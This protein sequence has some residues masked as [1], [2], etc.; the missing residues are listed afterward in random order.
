MTEEREIAGFVV[1]FT[2]GI[3]SATYSLSQFWSSHIVPVA[4][5]VFIAAFPLILLLHPSRRKRDR[6]VIMTL[7]V[8]AA[9]GCGLLTG[10]THRL[11]SIAINTDFTLVPDWLAGLGVRMKQRIDSL[12]FSHNSTNAVI[13]ALITGDRS[14]L[15]K[16]LSSI[17]RES[18][19]S[20]ILAL[21]GLHLG[22]I[23]GIIPRILSVAGK[24]LNARRL[25]YILTVSACAIYTA[26]TGAGASITRAFLFIFIG[27]T[28]ALSGR[29]RN[30]V[31]TL[32]ASLFIQLLF[33][34]GSAKDIGFQLSYAAMAGI[35]F[36]YPRLK[37]LWPEG[38]GGIMKR[39]WESAA[40]SISCQLT[41]GPLAYMYFGTFARHFLLTN[42]LAMPLT[43]IIIPISMLTAGLDAAGI[44]PD[45][46]LKATEILVCTMIDC[47]KTIATM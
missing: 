9:S 8:I 25:R 28:A 10:F 14:D 5:S 33:S 18:G 27:E 4:T 42:L 45:I 26:A 47:L 34:P 2:I 15:T 23:Y 11:A 31:V 12:P 41:T 44:C 40:I 16:E 39:I 1:P 21:S 24:S 6:R 22:I 13:S 7:V 36:I 38:T 37:G 19:A 43:C 17:F 46:L 3:I 20:H 35:A 29:H 30:I 32:M